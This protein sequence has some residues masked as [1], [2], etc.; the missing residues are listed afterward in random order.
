VKVARIDWSHL[1]AAVCGAIQQGERVARDVGCT[2]SYSA[3]NR[4]V[5]A[6]VEGAI[7]P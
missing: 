4:L 2:A 6:P 1:E 3:P 7:A 5:C